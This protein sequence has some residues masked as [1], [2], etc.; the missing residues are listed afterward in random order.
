MAKMRQTFIRG[1]V[2]L[3][4]IALSLYLIYWAFSIFENFFAVYLRAL[5]PNQMYIPGLGFLVT[6]GVIFLFGLFLNNFISNSIWSQ[7]ESKLTEVP[8]IKVVYSPL[9][10]LMNLFSKGQKD[11]QSVVVV[12]IQPGV[13]IFGLVTREHFTD[14][15]QWSSSPLVPVYIPLSYALGGIT[16]LIDKKNLEKVDIPV[17]K[18]LSLAIT[19]WVKTKSES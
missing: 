8:L 5:L 19:A 17:E 13:K 4:P 11:L 2:T 14:I 6:L 16:L 10:D 18:A 1:L 7:V 12:E 15:P 9:R 3:T